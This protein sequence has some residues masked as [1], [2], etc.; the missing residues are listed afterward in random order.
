MSRTVHLGEVVEQI[1]VG[2]VGSMADR[3]VDRGIPF[4][5]TL[6]VKPY[7]ISSED[8]KFIPPDFH[9]E[10]QKSRL[11]AGDVVVARTG[12]PGTAAVIPEWLGDANCSDLVVIRT[13]PKVDAR[14]LAYYLNSHHGQNLIRAR[15]VGSVQAHFN[16]GSAKKLPFTLRPVSEQRRIAEVLGALDDKIELNR[17]MN[18]TLEEM[19]QAIFK[20]WFIDFDGHD[21]LVESELGMIPRGWVPVTLGDLI[22]LDRGLSYRSKFFDPS[23][24]PMA[25]LKCI[26]PSGG[27]RRT[28][29]KYYGGEFKDKHLVSPGDVLIAMTDLTQKRVVIASPAIVP[30]VTGFDRILMSLDLT[31]ARPRPDSG[32][33]RL[34]LFHRLQAHDF[35][36]F[37]RGFANGTTVLHLKMDGVKR[38]RFPMPPS[39][40]IDTFTALAESLVGRIDCA[41]SESRTLAELRDTLLP[42]LISGEIRV[43]EA[44]E[45][46]EAVV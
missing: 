13:G 20:S 32:L 29:L 27:F 39:E 43:P 7:H 30:R 9:A 23:G 6:N 45:E 28:G 38:Y 2:W 36:S 40:R 19:A 34:W 1:T 21:D 26:R 24:L 25:N 46:V 33:T 5:R 8:M 17:K 42:K 11:T 35:K 22:T 41:D 37:A 16:I 31:C 44:E 10:I 15:N 14:Y 4:L 12:R 18:A 3:Y